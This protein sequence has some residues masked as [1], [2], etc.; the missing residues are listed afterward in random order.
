MLP[1][2][3]YAR[4][5]RQMV[6]MENSRQLRRRSDVTAGGRTVLVTEMALVV[7]SASIWRWRR[8]SSRLMRL[9]PESVVLIAMSADAAA[10]VLFVENKRHTIANGLK[11]NG[12][13]NKPIET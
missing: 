13:K 3:G 10:N 9:S 2:F 5:P 7:G 12:M 4:R 11:K 6:A 1:I 8:V